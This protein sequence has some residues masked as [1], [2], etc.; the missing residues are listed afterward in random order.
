MSP[1]FS[2]SSSYFLSPFLSFLFNQ[3]FFFFP[4]L[5]FTP[6][7]TAS[8]LSFS[9]PSSSRLPPFHSYHPPFSS[10]SLLSCTHPLFICFPC[11]CPLCFHARTLLLSPTP[12]PF[13]LLILSSFFFILSCLPPC[14]APGSGPMFRSTTVAVDPGNQS[15]PDLVQNWADIHAGGATVGTSERSSLL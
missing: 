1:F 15:R 2:P 11:S 7:P 6:L 5:L 13:C 12:L 14:S 8:F 10:Y 9:L 3:V 4:F